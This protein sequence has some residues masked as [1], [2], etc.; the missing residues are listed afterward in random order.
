MLKNYVLTVVAVMPRST[1]KDVLV[2]A[3]VACIAKLFTTVVL[4]MPS[5]MTYKIISGT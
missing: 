4:V 1:S 5:K 3:A 2:R